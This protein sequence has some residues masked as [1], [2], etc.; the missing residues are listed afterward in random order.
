MSPDEIA[1]ATVGVWFTDSAAHAPYDTTVD[2]PATND[3]AGVK[4]VPYDSPPQVIRKADPPSSKPFLTDR[5]PV[6]RVKVSVWVTKEGKVRRSV[7]LSS[8][9][10]SLN[11]EALRLSMAW[12]FKPPYMLGHPVACWVSI[13]FRFEKH[14]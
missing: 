8:T 5:D 9:N 2:A 11:K 1:S 3:T 10:T 12:Q 4:M 13:P 7:L 14:D 6:D